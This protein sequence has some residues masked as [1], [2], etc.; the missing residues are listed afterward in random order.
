MPRPVKPRFVSEDPQV[1]TFG[2]WE[3]PPT[4]EATLSV[5][6]MEALRLSD[7]EGMDQDGAANLMGVSRQTYGRILAEARAIVA[8]ALVTGKVLRV[9]GGNYQLRGGRGRRM[10]RHGGRGLPD[11]G[12][13]KGGEIMPK[14]D[15]KGPDGQGPSGR[16]RGGCGGKGRGPCA[17]A[18]SGPDG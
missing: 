9:E 10:R 4:G 5:E 1:C 12:L 6:G 17:G 18:G 13:P 11:A 3:T 16:G 14:G 7:H 15:G 8:H 2:P